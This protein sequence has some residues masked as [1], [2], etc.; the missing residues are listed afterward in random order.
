[1]KKRILYIG[2][3]LSDSGSNVT[4]IETLGALLKNE[5][6]SV[7]T[8]SSKK[9]KG[10]RLLDMLWQTFKNRNVVDVV[11]IDTY[12]TLNFYYAVYVAKLC[13]IFNLD[14]I[15]I[16]RGGNLPSRLIKS[17]KLSHRLFNEAKTNV[18][19]SNYLLNAF[20]ENGYTNLTYIPNTIEI[21]NY[22]FIVRKEI[23][24]KLL[25]VRSFSEIYN[26]TLA[27]SI[28]EELHKN[29]INASLCMVGPEKDG[30]LAE[31]RTIVQQKNLPI[32]FTGKLNKKEWLELSKAYDVFINTTNIDNTPISVIEAMALGMP[33]ISTD[34][35]GLPFLIDNGN[36]GILVPPNNAD[37]FVEVILDLLSKI[38]KV[39]QLSKNARIAVEK[40]DWEIVKEKWGEVLNGV[41]G[42]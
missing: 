4:S 22:P 10:L 38:E 20:I 14:Y 41:S 34:V 39:S 37:N 23:N 7:V 30:S 3:K 5:G 26:P 16:L 25:W 40:F 33:V 31:C 15:P 32:T 19:P 18:A 24:P 9:N 13:R 8:S 21:K 28:V 12:S 1:M 35:G 36:T 11:L 29:N 27:I 6:Y 42:E 17:P 2:N